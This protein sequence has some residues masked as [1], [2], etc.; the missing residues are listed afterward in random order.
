[1][2]KILPGTP[3]SLRVKALAGENLTSPPFL[4]DNMS[5][6]DVNPHSRGFLEL[7]G[8]EARRMV[9]AASASQ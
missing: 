8:V 6:H 7:P 2:G 4:D 3:L 9:M 1:M 5:G